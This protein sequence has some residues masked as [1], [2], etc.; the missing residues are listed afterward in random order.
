MGKIPGKTGLSLWAGNQPGTHF[1]WRVPA[2][3]PPGAAASAAMGR[4]WALSSANCNAA[5]VIRLPAKL[6]GRKVAFYGQNY[7]MPTARENGLFV[8]LAVGMVGWGLTFYGCDPAA[9]ASTWTSISSFSPAVAFSTPFSRWSRTSGLSA[10][11]SAPGSWQ[12]LA[13]RAKTVR[14]KT[15]HRYQLAIPRGQSQVASRCGS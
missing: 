6:Q 14:S 3:L 15:Y 13:F 12:C 10:Q 9:T 4:E 8:A 7:T 1:L 2:Q 5:R 11:R